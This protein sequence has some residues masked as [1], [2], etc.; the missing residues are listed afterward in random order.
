[1][2]VRNR[3][4][5]RSLFSIAECWLLRALA[6]CCLFARER[7]AAFAS[8]YVKTAGSRFE[9]R[10][11]G[12]NDFQS[13]FATKFRRSRADRSRRTGH[14]RAVSSGSVRSL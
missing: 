9:I 2:S 5:E 10:A 6:P 1:M 8:G 7:R 11:G 4:P 14:Y 3:R 13:G 12:L